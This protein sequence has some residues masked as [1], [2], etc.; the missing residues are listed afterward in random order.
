[1][2]IACMPCPLSCGL[3]TLAGCVLRPEPVLQ[4]MRAGRD[5]Q[6]EASRA[7]CTEIPRWMLVVA[8]ANHSR[9][10]KSCTTG[11]SHMSWLVALNTL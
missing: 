3:D 10:Q 7:K 11:R 6:D 5:F 8:P 1:M 4:E 2:W 9:L